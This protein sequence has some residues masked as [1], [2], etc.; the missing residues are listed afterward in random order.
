[1]RVSEFPREAARE[2]NHDDGVRDSR[3]HVDFVLEGEREDG[4]DAAEE[5]DGHEC[6]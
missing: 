5:V 2:T 1:M 6:E 3:E 4:E